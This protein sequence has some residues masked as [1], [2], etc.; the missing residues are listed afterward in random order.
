MSFI[1]VLSSRNKISI[2]LLI[3]NT[4][5]ILV[6]L[7][8]LFFSPFYFEGDQVPYNN[9]YD[10]IK[11]VNVLQGY[12]QYHLYITSDEPI[13][14]LILWIFSNLGIPKD[15][16]MAFANAILANVLTRLF[17][18]WRVSI[19]IIVF[20]IFTNFY[21]LVLYF[22]AERLKF[23]FIFFFI[24]VLLSLRVKKTYLFIVLSILTHVQMLILVLSRFFAMVMQ[25]VVSFFLTLKFKLKFTKVV[26][27][28]ILFIPIIFLS[29]H[30]LYKLNAYSDNS[31]SKGLLLNTFQPLI[32]LV[33]SLFYS[34]EKMA[35]FFIFFIIIIS[36][37]I[38]GPER[39]TMMA[40]LYFM[41]YALR[42]NKGINFG[43]VVTSFYYFAKSIIFVSNVLKNGHGF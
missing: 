34:R 40:Y 27:I 1:Q 35:T 13:H 6:L 3:R 12:L 9:A 10:G 30:I 4:I 24:A 15:V 21:L 29:E 22:S 42:I 25:S 28:I 19:G 2:E 11:G 20:I 32:F 41:F 7:L 23:A 18:K 5:T 33:L 39:V 26:F 38:V 14:F 37:S 31:A 17:F 8:S 36:S 16:V 43:V